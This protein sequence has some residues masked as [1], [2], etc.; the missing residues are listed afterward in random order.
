[1]IAILLLAAGSS[2]RMRGSDKLL[3]TVAGQPL[4]KLMAMRALRCRVPV[5]VTLPPSPHPRAAI[6]TETPV[7]RIAVPDADQ[8]MSASIRAGVSALTP[9]VTGVMIVPADMPEVDATD[10]QAM[11]DAYR[12]GEILRGAGGDGTPGHPV[13]FPRD[14]FEELAQISGD[15]GARD[16][17]VRHR[18]RL[19]LPPLPGTHAVTDLDTPE[20]WETWRARQSDTR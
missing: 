5:I 8:G 14:L 15:I 11:I 9:D 17:L 1:M 18:A 10:M 7:A 13:I 6:L 16:V 19:R 3:E 20:D 2:T 12:P 4:L